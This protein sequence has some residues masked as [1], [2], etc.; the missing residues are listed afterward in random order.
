MQGSCVL[1]RW[2][3]HQNHTAEGCWP[4]CSYG[5]SFQRRKADERPPGD[6]GCWQEPDALAGLGLAG[7]VAAAAVTPA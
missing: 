4:D 7:L 1:S 5:N 6:A 3:I 2:V